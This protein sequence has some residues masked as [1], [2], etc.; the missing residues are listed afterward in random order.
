M[1]RRLFRMIYHGTLMMVRNLRSY[2]MLS[3]SVVLSFSVLLGYL[4]ISDSTLFN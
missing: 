2:S 3:L 1:V 4:A